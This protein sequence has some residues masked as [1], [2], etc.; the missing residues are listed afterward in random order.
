LSTNSF[1]AAGRSYNEILS[2]LPPGQRGKRGKPLGKNSI[3]EILQNERYIGTYS[4]NKRKMKYFGE[5]AGGVPSDRAVVIDDAIQPIIDPETWEKVRK[6][7]SENKKN[8]LNKARKPGRVYLLSGILRCG[9]CGAKFVGTTST[10]KRGYEYKYYMCGNKSRNKT[11]SA[12]N[13]AAGPIEIIISQVLRESL[14]DGE[15]IEAMARAIMLAGANQNK[16][17]SKE[18]LEN[19]LA[20]VNKHQTNLIKAVRNGLDIETIREEIRELET[21]KRLLEE[22]LKALHPKTGVS[23]DHLINELR[24][25]AELLKEGDS[26]MKDLI[27]KYIVEIKVW[28]DNIEVYST[29]DITQLTMIPEEWRT[30]SAQDA[31]NLN[32]LGT[33]GCGG[34][35]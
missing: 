10:N 4:W 18:F 2:A 17:S 1:N 13:I 35:I 6:R 19:D 9:Y 29:A 12:K 16:A 34:G 23:R 22:K 32:V 25:D 24:K 8:T 26:C 11:C 31:E 3:Y 21:K 28:E 15:M 7:M 27:K 30:F 20:L 5:W 14:E 33:G